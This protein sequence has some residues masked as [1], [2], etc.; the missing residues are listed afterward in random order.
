MTGR[1]RLNGCLE[2]VNRKQSLGVTQN[3]PTMA[4]LRAVMSVYSGRQVKLDISCRTRLR[5]NQV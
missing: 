4:D 3:D 2:Q 5:A 1:S